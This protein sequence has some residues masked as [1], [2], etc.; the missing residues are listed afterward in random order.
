MFLVATKTM[1]LYSSREQYEEHL[2]FLSRS[3][4]M[5]DPKHFKHIDYEDG[6]L[7]FS[8]Y[9]LNGEENPVQNM[10]IGAEMRILDYIE[11]RQGLK[12]IHP[13]PK[14]LTAILYSDEGNGFLNKVMFTEVTA[15]IKASRSNRINNR[16]IVEKTK[17]GYVARELRGVRIEDRNV[18]SENLLN[19][20]L[21][22]PLTPLTRIDGYRFVFQT[23]AEQKLVL[24]DEK[25]FFK[26]NFSGMLPTREEMI[27]YDELNRLESKEKSKYKSAWELDEKCFD[28][29]NFSVIATNVRQSY[30][31]FFTGNFPMTENGHIDRGTVLSVIPLITRQNPKK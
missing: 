25:L 17:D 24:N 18:Q 1:G 28:N 15:S 5:P 31:P 19:D 29:D 4:S 26:R 10:P 13:L 21:E 16:I 7:W 3:S 30:S 23:G 22:N 9:P 6:E 2:R 20:G 11:K 12:L 8:D 14:E 27:T